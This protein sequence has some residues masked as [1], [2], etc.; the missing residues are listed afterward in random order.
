MEGHPT[1]VGD[2]YE[3]YWS[4]ARGLIDLTP[5]NPLLIDELS[6]LVT[7]SSAVLDFGCGDGTTIGTWLAAHAGSYTGVDISAAATAEA[8][9][10]GLDARVVGLDDRLPFADSSFDLVTCVEVLEHMFAPQLTLEEIKRVLRPGGQVFITVPN[11]AYWRRRA[12]LLV[13]GRWNPLGDSLAVEQP[14]RDPHI[15]FFTRSALA[16]MLHLGG[17]HEILVGGHGGSLVGELPGLRRLADDGRASPV[18]RSLERRLPGLFA[19]RL[20]A[21]ARS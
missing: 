2:Y 18:Y 1:D 12:D 7:F 13:L 5:A 20:N 21:V 15:R 3:R 10:L 16:R 6:G 4:T 19:Q 8:R 17:W 9:R 11:A 14:W